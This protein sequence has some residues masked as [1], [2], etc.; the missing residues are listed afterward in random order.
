[1][2]KDGTVCAEL[3]PDGKLRYHGEIL[4]MHT[5]AGKA[6]NLRAKRVNGFDVW[7][8]LRDNQLVSI[9]AIRENYRVSIKQSIEE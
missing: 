4:D 2:L 7:H 1:M 9:A 5:C 6:K 3:Q 8:V